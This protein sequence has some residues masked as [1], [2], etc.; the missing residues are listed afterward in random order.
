MRTKP[1]AIPNPVWT[2]FSRLVNDHLEFRLV[3]WVWARLMPAEPLRVERVTLTVPGWPA[4]WCG[5]RIAHLSDLHLGPFL[6]RAELH[7]VV[8]EVL[9]LRADLIVLTGDFVSRITRGELE[10]LTEELSRL[11][12]PAG[13]WGVLG[14]HDWRTD[15]TAVAQAV[16]RAGGRVLWNEHVCLRRGADELYV[17][18]VDDLWMGQSDLNRALAGVPD[19]GRVL[20][21]AHEPEYADTVAHDPRVLLQLSG[22]SHGGQVRLP[23]VGPIMTRLRDWK[24]VMGVYHI[25]GLTMYVSRGI[26]AVIPGI[27]WNCPPEVTLLTVG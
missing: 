15:A 16:T 26:G 4:G 18:G 12:A 24:Y 27:R 19:D 9:A 13:V 11:T 21:L 22:H 5:V 2:A 20:L 25:R 23:L 17:A 8:D 3:R 10:I 6:G 1:R 14:N 7:A